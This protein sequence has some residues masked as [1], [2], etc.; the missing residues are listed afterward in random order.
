MH[1]NICKYYQIGY[2]KFGVECMNNYIKEECSDKNCHLETCKK[3]TEGHV[4]ILKSMII[5]NLVISVNIFMR[6]PNI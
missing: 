4:L 2:C 1:L 3:D 6:N 5:I